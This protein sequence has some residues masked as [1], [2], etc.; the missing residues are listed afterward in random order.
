MKKDSC[1]HKF[2]NARCKTILTTGTIDSDFVPAIY[3]IYQRGLIKSSTV[4]I[5]VLTQER[6]HCAQKKDSVPNANPTL[7]LKTSTREIRDAKNIMLHDPTC[8]DDH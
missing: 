8:T 1:P 3:R 5:Q 7:S 6:Q 4:L 2:V